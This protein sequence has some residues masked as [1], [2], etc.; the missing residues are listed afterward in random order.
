M[1]GGQ[2]EPDPRLVELLNQLD[3]PVVG[4]V[5]SN[6]HGVDGVI[7]TADLVFKKILAP[8]TNS[9][10]KHTKGAEYTNN[11]KPNFLVTIGRSIISKNLKLFLREYKPQAHWH[12]GEGMAGDPVSIPYKNSGN[13][14]CNF[15]ERMVNEICQRATE[16]T[17]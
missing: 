3:V 7:K 2:T 4:D 10:C 13:S 16:S 15:F 6:L 8:E 12:I 1:L 5:I 17:E 11:F 9:G 14:P